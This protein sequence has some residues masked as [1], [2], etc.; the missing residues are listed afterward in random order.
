MLVICLPDQ[1]PETGMMGTYNKEKESVKFRT[2]LGKT[3]CVCET[4]CPQ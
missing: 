4:Q 1:G 2:N 3:R